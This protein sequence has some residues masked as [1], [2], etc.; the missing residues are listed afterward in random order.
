MRVERDSNTGSSVSKT[1]GR[2]WNTGTHSPNKE[3]PAMTNRTRL[4]KTL[5]TNTHKMH[6]LTYALTKRWLLAE[7]KQSRK[8]LLKTCNNVGNQKLSFIAKYVQDQVLV[9]D[10]HTNLSHSDTR[11]NLNIFLNVNQIVTLSP[12]RS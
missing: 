8:S 3:P 9:Y 4:H 1:K 11:Y 5:Q 12:L 7:T 2:K 10:I 6:T